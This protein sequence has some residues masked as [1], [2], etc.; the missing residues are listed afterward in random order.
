[1]SAKHLTKRFFGSLRAKPLDSA[2]LA[3]VRANLLDTEFALWDRFAVADKRHTHD[4]AKRVEQLLG[5]KVERPVIAAALL[6]DI[7]KIETQLGTF[8]RVMATLAG[9]TGTMTQKESWSKEDG[10]LGRAGRYLMHHETGAQMLEKAGSDPI[11]Y[12]WAREHE[13]L[14]TDW[15]L[16]EEITDA[17]WRADNGR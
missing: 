13:L 8:E 1:M 5:D 9:S 11:T 17:L 14:H 16:P 3:W 10:W 4:V 15:T 6:H 7:G 12:T 2:E